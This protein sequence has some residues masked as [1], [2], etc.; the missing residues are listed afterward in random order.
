[1]DQK[2]IPGVHY[3]ARGPKY[4]DLFNASIVI[5]KSPTHFRCVINRFE[6]TTVDEKIPNFLL[7]TY[8]TRYEHNFTFE[9]IIESLL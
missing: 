9:E 6:V 8:I 5:C 7:P 3:S 4:K 1:M 2:G